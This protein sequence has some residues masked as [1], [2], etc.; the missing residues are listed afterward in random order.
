MSRDILELNPQSQVGPG[1]G[2]LLVSEP[3]LPDPYFRR[4]VVLLCEHNHEG[5]FG[6]VLNRFLEMD[7]GD[8]MENMP[9]I[10]TRISIGGPVQSG[11]LYYLHTFGARVEGSLEVVDGVHMGGDFEQLRSLLATDPK[12]ARHV[13]FFVGYSGW[14]EKQLDKELNER[15]WLVGRADKRHVMNTTLKDLWGDTLRSMG[16][17]YAPLA[18]FPDDPALN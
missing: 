5:S 9:P 13:R 8:L 12:L 7:I 4:T 17:A 6:F 11:N 1:R 16:K 18:N 3:Y 10:R 15:S 14:G 2:R